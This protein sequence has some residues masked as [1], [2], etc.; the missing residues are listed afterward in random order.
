M[1]FNG[2]KIAFFT[3]KLQKIAQRLGASPPEPPAARGP[4]P[5]PQSAIHLNY[6]SFL[7]TFPKLDIYTF[8]LL[9]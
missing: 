5:K 4:V 7:N 8:Q 2:I 9:V 1:W 3:K 6:T